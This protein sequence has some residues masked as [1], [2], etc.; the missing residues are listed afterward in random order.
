VIE[1]GDGIFGCEAAAREYFKTSCSSLGYEQAALMAGAII[2][3]RVHSP[4]HPTRRLL[5][6]QQI[7]LRRMQFK[8]PAPAQAPTA[9]VEAPAPANESAPIDNPIMPP[10]KESAPVPQPFPQPAAPPGN[11]TPGNGSPP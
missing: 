3:P 11:R 8:P 5:R 9:P 10:A 7:I 1:W 2:N 4:A 6:R